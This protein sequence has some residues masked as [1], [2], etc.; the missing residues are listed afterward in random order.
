MNVDPIYLHELIVD[1][2]SLQE[3]SR[4]AHQYRRDRDEWRAAASIL[5]GCCVILIGAFL[6]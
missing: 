1:Q 2:R 6:V 5:F 3:T 4:L